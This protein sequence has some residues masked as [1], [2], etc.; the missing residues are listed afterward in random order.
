MR[1][2]SRALVAQS[3]R[4]LTVWSVAAVLCWSAV[5]CGS[6]TQPSASITAASMPVTPSSTDLTDRNAYLRELALANHVDEPF[7]VQ[8]IREIRPD[9]RDDILRTCMTEAGFPP[10]GDA[11]NSW[12]VPPPQ[13]KAFN[14]A[15]FTCDA[16]YP[17]GWKYRQPMNTDQLRMVYE[18]YGHELASC[19]RLQGFDSPQLPSFDQFITT[20]GTKDEYNPWALI[21]AVSTDVVWSKCEALPP[22]E[23][24]YP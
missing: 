14:I 21:P 10:A 11:S 16:A 15:M 24:L 5:A 9:E 19:I 1:E 7:D 4:H 22:Y 6:V 20:A 13:L 12:S 23:K 8:V 3:P 18:Y 17:I 2:R